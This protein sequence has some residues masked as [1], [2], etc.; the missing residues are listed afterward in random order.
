M[1]VDGKSLVGVN[2]FEAADILNSTGEVVEII[3]GRGEGQDGEDQDQVL[4]IIHQNNHSGTDIESQEES[5]ES[6]TEQLPTDDGK[7]LFC[8][9]L[10]KVNMSLSAASLEKCNEDEDA[11]MMMGGSQ[12]NLPQDVS[13]FDVTDLLD[14]NDEDLNEEDEMKV[15]K[16]LVSPKDP[17]VSEVERVGSLSGEEQVTNSVIGLKEDEI[18]SHLPELPSC[19]DYKTRYESLVGKLERS[20]NLVRQLSSDLKTVTSQL[21]SRDQTMQLYVENVEK[22]ITQVT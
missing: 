14:E 1:S 11:K 6:L 8:L 19:C 9:D 17:D 7:K 20:E 15:N 16:K 21:V 12:D 2:Q 3:I 18:T 4:Q 22:L 13:I 10:E 5:G